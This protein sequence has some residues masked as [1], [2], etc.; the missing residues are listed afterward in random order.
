MNN[1]DFINNIIG[2]KFL[3]ETLNYQKDNSATLKL[4]TGELRLIN[5][6]IEKL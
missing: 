3:F 2:I 4:T 1:Q 5:I 6:N